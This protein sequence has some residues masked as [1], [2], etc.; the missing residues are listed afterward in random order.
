[1]IKITS[2]K[3]ASIVQDLLVWYDREKRSLPWRETA[4]PYRIWISEIM[5]QQTRVDTVIPFYNRFLEAFPSVEVLAESPEQA[6]LKAWENMGY[7]SRARNLHAAAKAIVAV[8]GGRIPSTRKEL[9][10]LAGIGAYTTGAILS[11]A[12]G[13][14]V[15]A[16]DG[17]VRRVLSRL[18]GIR[19]PIDQ[20][21][22][23]GTLEELAATLV[24]EQRPGDFNQ[25]LM[26]LGATICRSADPLC[27]SCPLMTHCQ[28]HRLNIQDTIPLTAKR[29][30]IPHREAVAAI[31][32]NRDG[33]LLV[34]QRPAE[35]L[36]ASFWRFPGGFIEQ[37]GGSA[38]A[39][40]ERRVKEELG[41]EFRTGRHLTSADHQ[42]T[43]FRVTLHAYLGRIVKGSPHPLGCA[44]WCWVSAE[45]LQ[46]L[47]FSKVDRI[48]AAAALGDV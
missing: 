43:H 14:S 30:A 31:I 6:V 42:Y 45:E 11:M 10:S 25:A 5:L 29:P 15:P 20:P 41:V 27:A 47:P 3:G 16:V 22:V 23:K 44:A 36:L 7:Y 46:N 19:E 48:I 26:D 24:P 35:G 18:F 17:N 9:S 39:S 4:D 34:V 38:A 40:L 1:M 33:R 21:K 13:Q 32:R 8:F 2:K 37:T 28:A 12:Y